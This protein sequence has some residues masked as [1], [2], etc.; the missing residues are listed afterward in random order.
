MTAGALKTAGENVVGLIER[1]GRDCKGQIIVSVSGDSA[2]SKDYLEAVVAAA[3]NTPTPN[4]YFVTVDGMN[5]K[6]AEAAKALVSISKNRVPSTGI[7]ICLPNKFTDIAAVALSQVGLASEAERVGS[8]ALQ[9]GALNNARGA[10][11]GSAIWT[12]DSTD[13]ME[14]FFKA[15]ATAIVTNDPTDLLP[16]IFGARMATPSLR[17]LLPATTDVIVTDSS[18]LSCGC[19]YST[20]GCK[21]SKTAPSGCLRL[22]LQR[23]LDLWRR[24]H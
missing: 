17:T 20:G 7:S 16:A 2:N 3:A 19:D 9:L 1:N 11:A 14:L 12:L 18:K 24:H 4:R 10:M 22:F 15:G 21:V 13:S 8:R 5:S 23:G 6:F